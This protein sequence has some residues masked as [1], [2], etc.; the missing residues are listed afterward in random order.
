[1]EQRDFFEKDAICT[2]EKDL[3]VRMLM[4]QYHAAPPTVFDISI[5]SE[6][7]RKICSFYENIRKT[8]SKGY[9]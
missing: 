4:E 6:N 7:D 1:M 8:V 9:L 3:E 2:P 5:V